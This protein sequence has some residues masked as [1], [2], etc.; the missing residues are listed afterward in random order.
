MVA[1]GATDTPASEPKRIMFVDDDEFLLDGL[2]DGLRTHRSR[3]AMRFL[4]SGH[5]ALESLEA[6][7]P[8]VVI[9]DLRMPGM[10]GATLL[11]AIRDR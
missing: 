2:R 5:G 8:D 3:W 4:S 11:E 9:S 6:E 10:D 7:P 1:A